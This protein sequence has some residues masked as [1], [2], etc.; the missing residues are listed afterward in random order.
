MWIESAAFCSLNTHFDYF[1]AAIVK[2][3]DLF[4]TA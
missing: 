4:L 1:I 3:N 2:L